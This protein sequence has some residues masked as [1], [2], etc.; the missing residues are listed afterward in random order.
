MLAVEIDQPSKKAG[1][2]VSGLATRTV[3]QDFSTLSTSLG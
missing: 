3:S 2:L 1:N